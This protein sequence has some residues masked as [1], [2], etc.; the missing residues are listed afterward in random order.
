MSWDGISYTHL[1]ILT[2]TIY[3]NALVYIY[4]SARTQM[5][6]ESYVK[7]RTNLY[8]RRLLVSVILYNW[9]SRTRDTDTRDTDTRDTDTRDT[10]TRDTDTRDTDTQS[11]NIDP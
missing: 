11:S 9:P 10:D 3:M 5:N 6:I 8:I 1:L 7:K 4:K 2:V